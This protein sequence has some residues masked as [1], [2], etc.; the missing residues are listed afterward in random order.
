M[1]IG[2]LILLEVFVKTSLLLK[3]TNIKGYNNKALDFKDV[4]VHLDYLSYPIIHS[5]PLQ[6]IDCKI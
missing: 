6:F 4:C 1:D 3:V 2:D 5:L